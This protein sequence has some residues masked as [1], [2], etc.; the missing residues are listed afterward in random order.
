[1]AK[2]DRRESDSDFDLPLN[3]PT[4]DQSKMDLPLNDDGDVDDDSDED[5]HEAFDPLEGVDPYG[6]P[7]VL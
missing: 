4:S 7:D 5:G 3:V 6:D 2:E 1:M